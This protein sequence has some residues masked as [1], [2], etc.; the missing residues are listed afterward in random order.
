M[1]EPSNQRPLEDGI[2]TDFTDRMS[3]GGYLRLDRILSAQHPL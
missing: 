2:T 3:Y 1:T